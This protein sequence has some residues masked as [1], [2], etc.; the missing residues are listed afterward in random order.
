M[1]AA[2]FTCWRDN[3]E[4]KQPLF[5]SLCSRLFKTGRLVLERNIVLPAAAACSIPYT[6]DILKTGQLLDTL[7]LGEQGHYTLGRAPNNDIV[8]DHPSSS[9]CAVLCCAM[10]R[11]TQCGK[12]VVL[13]CCCMHAAVHSCW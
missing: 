1:L 5:A 2:P 4:P 13:P 11:S 10:L 9:R 12:A 6:L 8:L 7:Q 3:L